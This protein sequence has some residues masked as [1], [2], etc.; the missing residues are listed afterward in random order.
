MDVKSKLLARNILYLVA[1][2]NLAMSASRLMVLKFTGGA[3][4]R[5][6]RPDLHTGRR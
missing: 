6:L 2:F 1:N 3:M 4:G 5:L